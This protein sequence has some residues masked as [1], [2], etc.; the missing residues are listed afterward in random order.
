MSSLDKV[1]PKRLAGARL[2]SDALREIHKAFGSERAERR[3]TQ[4]QIAQR[5]EVNKSCVNRWLNGQENLTLRSL[6]ELAWAMDHE[7]VITFVPV[8][9]HGGGQPQRDA[10]PAEPD[11][12]S[13]P[14]IEA[15]ASLP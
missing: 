4:T 9:A 10:A 3:L 8:S 11:A 13:A 5:L 1:H 15:P 2:I 6:A 12:A 7:V 14:V